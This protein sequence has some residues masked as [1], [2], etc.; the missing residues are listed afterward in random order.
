MTGSASV[1]VIRVH[2]DDL[3]ALRAQLAGLSAALAGRVVEAGTRLEFSGVNLEV[4]ETQPTGPAAITAATDVRIRP[5]DQPVAAPAAEPPA[6]PAAIDDLRPPSEPESGISPPA[7]SK[8]DEPGP[9]T[10]QAAQPP[11][12]ERSDAASV[13]TP[14]EPEGGGQE[15]SHE[16]REDTAA[17]D[18]EAEDS[19]G[20]RPA[21]PRII[22]AAAGVLIILLVAIL[23]ALLSG[24]GGDGSAT[25]MAPASSAAAGATST[26]QTT[27]TAAPYARPAALADCDAIVDA[28]LVLLQDYLD[29]TAQADLAALDETDPLL[30]EMGRHDEALNNRARTLD[31]SPEEMNARLAAG[32]GS[33]RVADGNVVGQF[34]I[35]SIRSNESGY[36]DV[37]QVTTTSTTAPATST[38]TTTTSTTSTTTTTLPPDELEF[39]AGPFPS[40]EAGIARHLAPFAIDYSGDCSG[41]E[42]GTWCSGCWGEPFAEQGMV[43]SVGAAQGEIVG[44]Y[45]VVR[46]DDGWVLQDF[47]GADLNAPDGGLPWP[48]NRDRCS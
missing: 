24:R 1:V 21:D 5:S 41:A 39:P 17:A 43:W 37:L 7:T 48:V 32:V 9:A 31:C 44:F 30:V 8:R 27:T 22:G 47:A 14:A 26:T 28:T 42:L 4:V 3:N 34:L 46:Q 29:A 6:A 12:V 38:T 19:S 10:G 33:L 13:D 2:R 45:L 11:A 36:F 20:R 25:T 16:V 40:I 23:L 35:E 15:P 18:S